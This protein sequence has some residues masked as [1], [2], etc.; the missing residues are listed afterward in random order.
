MKKMINDVRELEELLRKKKIVI[1]GAG[2]VAERFY[3]SLKKKGIDKNV[4][5]FVTTKGKEK[6][7]CGLQVISID[8]LKNEE[9]LII[10][11]A[12][13]ESIKNEIIELLEDR[14]I[15][16]YIWIY[17]FQFQMMLGIPVRENIKVPLSDIV[18]KERDYYGLAVRYLALEQ[19]YNK[20]EI[21]YEL[22]IKACSMSC[23][24][25]TAKARL[26]NFIKLIKSWEKDGYDETRPSS[27]LN[28]YTVI[29]GTHRIAIAVYEKKSYIV[30]NMY[31]EDSE[32]LKVHTDNARMTKECMEKA[33]F[34]LEE[35][36]I[37]EE[38]RKQI[39]TC[40]L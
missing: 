9:S 2:Y 34:T 26:D 10:C 29:D 3:R 13:H 38:K 31:L 16:N 37:L 15:Y 35:V 28:D 23:K 21:G 39:N 27:I 32:D 17:P 12:V 20:N 24:K 8:D 7:A 30:C 33:G 25:E 36:R 5:C 4:I 1:Y 14:G 18:L 40:Y 22:Y 11:V 6:Q 19:Y